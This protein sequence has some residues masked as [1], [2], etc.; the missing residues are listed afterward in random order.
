MTGK[1]VRY[2]STPKEN[3][4]SILREGLKA[5]KAN[6]PNTYTR[7]ILPHLADNAELNNKIYLAKNK[8]TAKV[9]SRSRNKVWADGSKILKIELDYDKDIKGKKNIENP[10][11]LGA[12]NWKEYHQ[13]RP[14][15]LMEKIYPEMAEIQ[16]KQAYKLLGKEGTEIFDHDINPSKIVGGKGYK[17]RSLKDVRNYIKNN[18]KRFLKGAVPVVAGAGLLTAGVILKNK[19]KNEK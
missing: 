15:T 16:S 18:P 6:D 5:E 4:E 14:K 12:K 2:H 3:V 13:R 9:V 1:E 19:H 17:R 7:T 11:L 10:E 8:R